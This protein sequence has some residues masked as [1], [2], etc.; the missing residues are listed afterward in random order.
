M[1][2]RKEVVLRSVGTWKS[3]ISVETEMQP[4]T[5]ESFSAPGLRMASGMILSNQP[6]AV[7]PEKLEKKLTAAPERRDHAGRQPTT[8]C[9]S[10]TGW[11]GWVTVIEQ[12]GRDS[13]IG[14]IEE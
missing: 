9:R 7:R 5:V 12:A 6:S 8:A 3:G 13:P 1:T 10:R 11:N 2:Y 4:D 14:D